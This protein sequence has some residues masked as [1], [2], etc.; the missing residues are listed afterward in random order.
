MVTQ[1]SFILV[2]SNRALEREISG[3]VTVTGSLTAKLSRLASQIQAQLKFVKKLF[4]NLCSTCPESHISIL[5]S[6]V[7]A[8]VN[9]GHSLF[10]GIL[11]A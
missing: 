6:Q 8:T 1:K 10:S 7:D 3:I 2:Y 4:F 11:D 5:Q 9:L